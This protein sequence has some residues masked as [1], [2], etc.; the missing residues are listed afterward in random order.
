M[1][2]Y[3][4]P[5]CGAILNDQSG[6]DPSGGT[7]ICTECGTQLMDDDVYDGDM[8]KGIAWY[9]DKCGALMNR[10]SGFSDIYDFWTCS[11]CGH[12][13]RI[14]EEEIEREKSNNA[15]DEMEDSDEED[16]DDNECQR[17]NYNSTRAVQYTNSVELKQH[18]HSVE[19]YSSSHHLK[20]L[21][22]VAL[23]LIIAA[24]SLFGFWEY[25]KLIPIA[26]S[27]DELIGENYETVLA[28]LESVGFTNVCTE[29]TA[30]LDISNIEDENLVYRIE[31]FGIAKFSADTKF[32]YDIDIVIKYRSLKLI[33][34]PLSNEEAEKMNYL[35]A[36]SAFEE[37]GFVNVHTEVKYD[38]IVGLFEK[39]GEIDLVTIDGEKN[40]DTEIEFRP[41]AEIEI[42][43]HSFRRNKPK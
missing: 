19:K 2:E 39:D 28:A 21:F 35:D 41:D 5:K 4:C 29:P 10:Q 33:T 14:T 8:Y 38:L 16:E 17:S 22:K 6:F 42:I 15:D 1:D 13:N 36:V 27:Y 32:P 43:Y 26:Y 9:C 37:A 24:I 31:V 25:Q 30:N 34:S 11:E 18:Y 23:F 7:W 20:G 40:F 12:C 3:F